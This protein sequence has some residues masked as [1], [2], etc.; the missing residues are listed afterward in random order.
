MMELRMRMKIAAS[1][2]DREREGER[3]RDRE[4]KEEVESIF[5]SIEHTNADRI[6]LCAANATNADCA[7]NKKKITQ[8]NESLSLIV[9]L[10]RCSTM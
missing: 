2:K 6:T 9:S 8:R 7:L 1:E 10:V 3:G 5:L 4:K